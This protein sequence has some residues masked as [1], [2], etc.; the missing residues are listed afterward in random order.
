[1]RMNTNIRFQNSAFPGSLPHFRIISVSFHALGAQK[2]WVGFVA[3]GKAGLNGKHAGFTLQKG[4]P[5]ASDQ[6]RQVWT[7]PGIDSFPAPS[8]KAGDLA[9]KQSMSPSPPRGILLSVLLVLRGV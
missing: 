5:E 6:T 7:A 2:P 1:M 8:F 9:C 3:P 4:K